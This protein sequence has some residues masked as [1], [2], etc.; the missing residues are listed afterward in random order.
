MKT[1]LLILF[2]LIMSAVSSQTFTPI[3]QG[4][5]YGHMNIYI[6]SASLDGA[7]LEPGDEIAAFSRGQCVGFT[8]ITS[9][10]IHSEFLVCDI[11]TSMNDGTN[12]GFNPGDSIAFKIWDKSESKEVELINVAYR[13]DLQ[14][15]STGLYEQNGSAFADLDAKNIYKKK[16][17]LK[18]G[19]NTLSLPLSSL[20]N[21]LPDFFADL[22][23]SG[24]LDKVQNSR[25]QSFERV[26]GSTWINSIGEIN[27]DEIYIVIVS[28]DCELEYEGTIK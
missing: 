22:I 24:V 25:G 12:N 1:K 8:T 19:T 16:V 5:G 15:W 20:S 28:K 13:T 9:N 10:Y 2:A 17:L 18:S 4:N 23:D 7:A 21:S 3:W 6:A 27:P 14:W 26:N 11:I